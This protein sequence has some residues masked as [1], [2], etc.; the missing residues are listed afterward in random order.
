MF[1]GSV[2][3]EVSSF[4][5]IAN[6]LKRISVTSVPLQTQ[7]SCCTLSDEE[8]RLLLGCIDGSLALL[9]RH[10]GLTRTVKAAFIA[11]IAAWHPKGVSNFKFIYNYMYC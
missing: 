8:D 3:V 6:S 2:S 7:V 4:E 10:R 1:V 11:T 5:L 9:N